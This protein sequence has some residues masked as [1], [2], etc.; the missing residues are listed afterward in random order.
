MSLQ[1]TIAI[2][3]VAETL[4]RAQAGKTLSLER[5]PLMSLLE[6]LGIVILY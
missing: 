6:G 5:M 1:D 2:R 4:R 3:P